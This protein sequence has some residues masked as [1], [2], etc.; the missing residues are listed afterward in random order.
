M[1][2]DRTPLVAVVPRALAGLIPHVGTAGEGLSFLFLAIAH[3][4]QPL[5]CHVP[6]SAC[7]GPR[8][9]TGQPRLSAQ[10]PAPPTCSSRCFPTGRR[11]RLTRISR[12]PLPA[13]QGS[14][15]PSSATG[16]EAGAGRVVL[17]GWS[18]SRSGLGQRHSSLF[19]FPFGLI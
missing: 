13:R 11:L 17:P 1:D 2:G 16:L 14:A 10:A 3:A 4:Q 8:R 5:L 12:P 7:P 19:L 9:C 18:K 6:H 15:S